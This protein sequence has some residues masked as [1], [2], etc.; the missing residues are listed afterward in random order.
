MVQNTV[1][2]ALGFSWLAFASPLTKRVLSPDNTCGGANGYTCNPN[3]VGGGSCCSASGQ[4]GYTAAFCGTGCQSAFGKCFGTSPAA[5]QSGGV[6]NVALGTGETASYTNANTF[7]FAGASALPAGLVA[8]NYQIGDA[9]TKPYSRT[10]LP[11]DVIVSGGGY[12]QLKI[13]GGQTTAPLKCAQVVTA[14]TNIKYA[15]VRTTAIFSSVA[16]SCH[17][18]FFY[19]NDNQELDIEYLTNSSSTSNPGDGSKP[20]QY[21][22]QP[23][24]TTTNGAHDTAPSPSD[25][26]T[27]AHEYR[28][29]WVAGKTLFYLDGVLQKVFTVS[30]PSVPG[31]WMWNNWA[32]GSPYWS[33]G[34]P[35]SD[36]I[37]KISNIVMY[38][39]TSSV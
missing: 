17:G 21:T 37:M 20:M 36:N 12:M 10:F 6:Y 5:T 8:S 7:N 9:S 2:P 26:T 38:Y 23:T 27:V 16:G 18:I 39:N 22:N 33:T 32:N 3:S 1:L 35:L 30:V 25:A 4:C 13:P 28:M 11:E 34:P 15:S 19:A 14:A 31:P 29:D 24:S